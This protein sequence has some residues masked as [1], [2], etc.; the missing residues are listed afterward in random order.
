MIGTGQVATTRHL[1]AFEKLQAE[2]KVRLVAV[3]DVSEAKARAAAEKFGVPHVFTDYSELLALTEIDAV[4][5]CTTNYLHKQPV[6]DAFAAGKHVLCEKPLALNG[7]EGVEMVA[8]GRGANRQLQVG[9]NLRFGPGAQSVRR[10]IDDGRLGDMYHVRAQALRRRGIPSHG[11]FTDKAKQGGGP[12]IDIGAHVLD[13]SLW[14][15]DFPKPVSVSGQTQTKFGHR[16]NI[17][18]LRGQWD[19]GNYTV[20]DF[21]SGFVRFENGATL[22]LESSFAAN[23]AQD[24]FQTTLLGT[25]GGAFLDLGAHPLDL[26]V[27]TYV[28]VLGEVTKVA[29]SLGN[30]FGSYG[31]EI[32]EYGTGLLTFASG[33]TAV[34]SASWVDAKFHAPIEVYGIEGQIQ[35][36]DGKVHYYS[37]KV[38][39]ADG[40]RVTDLPPAGPHAFD[41]FWDKL[42][43]KPLAVPLVGVEQAALSSSLMERMYQAAGRSTTTGVTG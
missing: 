22:V 27:D 34:L 30:Q 8:A 37:E 20:E 3:C 18:G 31:T 26:I 1:P 24:Q 9:Y 15:L 5:V 2:G 16:E 7:V 21:A 23:I 14:L 32:D 6:L 43:G 36:M 4:A 13:L 12:L 10:F 41:L 33:A 28:P 39:G 35:V 29:A 40:K 19:R 38:E 11:H 25:E 42:L 17:V